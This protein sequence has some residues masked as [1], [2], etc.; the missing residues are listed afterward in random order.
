M[1]EHADLEL[2]AAFREGL[3]AAAD[4]D[5]VG[6]HLSGC[7]T[8]AQR[9]A[10]LEEVTARLAQAPPPPLP[11]GLVQR[12]DAVLAA[13]V[14]A[15]QTANEHASGITAT[16]GSA[17]GEHKQ[18]EHKQGARRR[19][20]SA[21]SLAGRSQARREPA[22]RAPAGREEALSGPAGRERAGHRRSGG[23]LMASAL[24]PLAAAASVCLLAGG[25]YLLLHSL[26]RTSPSHSTAAG[27][28]TGAAVSPRRPMYA[29]QASGAATEAV[30]V[31]HSGTA[32]QHGQL[33][34]QAAAVAS[35]NA[36]RVQPPG[37]AGDTPVQPSGISSSLAGCLQRVTG[38]QRGRI[39]DMATY[40]GRQAMVIIA[41]AS[42]GAGGHVWV[43]G[44]GC[45]A[46]AADLITASGF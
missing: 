34:A 30:L 11:P 18:G 45:S 7:A 29:P 43:V 46:A 27:S 8:C 26:T 6:R 14:A 15:A 12:L 38:S 10:A 23:G 37:K 5:R 41:P 22:G 44:P 19:D 36:A 2:I 24:R 16:T 32:Y 1:N 17:P 25:G 28:K 31:V 20:R 13:E 39:V 42:G 33:Q 35:E 4:G 40:Q 9:Q 3:L 21:A